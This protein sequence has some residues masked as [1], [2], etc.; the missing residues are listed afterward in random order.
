MK[1][2]KMLTTVIA[3]IVL[4]IPT[5]IGII[6]YRMAQSSPVT[7][8]SVTKMVLRTPKDNEYVFDKSAETQPEQQI[9]GSMITYFVTANENAASLSS[10]PTALAGRECFEA[11]YY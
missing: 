4:F 2:K 10:L 7:K 11:T 8:S 3:V 1:S 9:D 5:I 6:N